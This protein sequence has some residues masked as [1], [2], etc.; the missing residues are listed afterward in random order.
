MTTLHDKN[1]V[2]I[3]SKISVERKTK[4]NNTIVDFDMLNTEYSKY[5]LKNF[6]TEKTKYKQY[7][8]ISRHE[9]HRIK[10]NT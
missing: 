2:H 3:N 7:N 10:T 8:S 9:N 6:G 5:K 1:T 4:I